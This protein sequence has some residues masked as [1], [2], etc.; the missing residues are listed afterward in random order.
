MLN[1]LNEH[2]ITSCGLKNKSYKTIPLISLI[3][4]DGVNGNGTEND[5]ILLRGTALRGR[6]QRR[7]IAVLTEQLITLAVHVVL[8]KATAMKEVMANHARR[9][10][11][12]SLRDTGPDSDVV[13]DK[14]QS[15]R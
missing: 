12:T 9:E 6:A 15:S 2:E 7:L 10:T 4:R 5:R 3:C 8:E 13:S 14:S 11:P 1:E